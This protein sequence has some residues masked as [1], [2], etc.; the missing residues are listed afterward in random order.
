MNE[1]KTLTLEELEAEQS[2][3][4]GLIKIAKEARIAALRKEL[5]ELLNDNPSAGADVDVTIR[6]R[7]QV[8]NQSVTKRLY[9]LREAAVSLGMSTASVR[10]LVERGL[11][12]PNRALRTFLFPAAELDRFTSQT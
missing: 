2:K 11:L 9:T 1:Q 10:K 7:S 3:I 5:D 8:A 6:R 4:A 12:K